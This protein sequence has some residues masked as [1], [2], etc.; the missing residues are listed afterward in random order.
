MIT[1]KQA[2]KS[3]KGIRQTTYSGLHMYAQQIQLTQSNTRIVLYMQL[4]PKQNS[5]HLSSM[6]FH[7]Q[8][9]NLK[10]STL[11]PELANCDKIDKLLFLCSIES[12]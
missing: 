10:Y 7:S 12:S 8:L 3:R 2:Q 9:A 1:Y 6:E 11:S 5:T 4:I